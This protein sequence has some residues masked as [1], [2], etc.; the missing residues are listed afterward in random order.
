MTRRIKPAPIAVLT[1]ECG[2]FCSADIFIL[3]AANAPEAA[4]IKLL[5][6]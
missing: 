5:S 1:A 3:I 6:L 2:L 4:A